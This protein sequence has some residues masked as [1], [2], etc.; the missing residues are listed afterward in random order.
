MFILNESEREYRNGDNGPKYLMVGPRMNFA[1]VQFQA[2][3]DFKAHY[4]KVMEENF[5]VLEG[6]VEIIV[7]GVVH[8]LKKGD[9]I[10]IE[11]DEKHYLRNVSGKPVKMVATLA[12][13]QEKDKVEIENYPAG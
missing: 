8:P 10:H 5:F 11:P 1:V 13:Y 4:H 6:E 3:Q 7:D 12:P 9:F 2:G